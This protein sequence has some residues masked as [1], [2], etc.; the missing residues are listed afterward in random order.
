MDDTAMRGITLSRRPLSGH[1]HWMQLHMELQPCML[2][3]SFRALHSTEMAVSVCK[4][5][6]WLSVNASHLCAAVE[7]LNQDHA[8]PFV[9]RILSVV[10][11]VVLHMSCTLLLAWVDRANP[12]RHAKVSFIPM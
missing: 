1:F 10:R 8:H 7:G 9:S 4:A 3:A 5:S 11:L 12:I 6:R 2:I